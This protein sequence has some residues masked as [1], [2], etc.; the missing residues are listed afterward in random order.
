VGGTTP[1]DPALRCEALS[2]ANVRTRWRLALSALPIVVV[3]AVSK[4]VLD[5]IG[6]GGVEL[7]PLY[8]GL[9]AGNIF[10]LG[11]LLAGTLADYKESEKMPGDLVSSM[12]AIADECLILHRD[13]GAR[14]ARDCL[15]Q[16]AAVNDGILAWLENDASPEPVLAAIR[17]FNPFFLEFE[18]MTQPN[19]IVRL[20]Q[21]Q[22][23]LRRM[24]IRVDAIRETSF[25]TAGYAIAEL[26]SALL[27]TGLLFVEV[28]ALGTELFVLST[29]AFLLAYM[30]LLIKD[31]DDPFHYHAGVAAGAAEVSLLP[32]ERLRT[33]LGEELGDLQQN[34][35]REAAS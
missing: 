2:L 26:T 17:G 20:K 32:L 1:L 4:A 24:T 30:L 29:L 33:R 6:I 22:T 31:L 23:A 13:K 35:S 3:V 16:V 14:A 34:A 11:F 19:F 28:G 15:A 21:E 10:L 5:L 8:T 18:G 12:E 7:N 25:V 9:V 27:I